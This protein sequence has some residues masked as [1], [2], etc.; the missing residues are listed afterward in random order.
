MQLRSVTFTELPVVVDNMHICDS[1]ASELHIA[2]KKHLCDATASE[3]AE[4]LHLCDTMRTESNFFSPMLT[5]VNPLAWCPR[6]LDGLFDTPLTEP[7]IST[8]SC[9]A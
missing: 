7:L 5:S 3:F 2:E 4:K 9:S 1:T 6:D 8:L